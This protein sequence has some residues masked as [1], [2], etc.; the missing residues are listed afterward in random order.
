L[1]LQFARTRL[2]EAQAVKSNAS[3]L[4]RVLDDMDSET[5]QGVRLLT[6][7]AMQ[8]KDA[9]SLDAVD[10]FVTTQRA[11]AEKLRGAAAA[12]GQA[13][14]QKSVKL[15]DA[16]QQR[17]KALRLVLSCGAAATAGAD[18]IGPQTTGICNTPGTRQDGSNG[19]N[20]PTGNTN[21]KTGTDTGANTG[22]APESS[23]TPVA[24]PSPTTAA[25]PNEVGTPTNPPKG[26]SSK[27]GGL[28]DGLHG[29]VGG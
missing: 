8:H 23:G 25:V 15:L 20:G 9:S 14:A 7:S 4:G 6:T 1:Y 26:K 3:G 11:G 24:P 5:Q 13:R 22:G 12:D 17:S 29:L 27:D 16:I 28:L 2:D 10:A 21:R 19:Q 18:A